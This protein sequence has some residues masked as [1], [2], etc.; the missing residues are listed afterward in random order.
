MKK[1]GYTIIAGCAVLGLISCFAFIGV[2]CSNDEYKEEQTKQEEQVPVP[3]YVSPI[4]P[5]QPEPE[6][7]PEPTP[8][9]E[10]RM[11]DIEMARALI[12]PSI[13]ET[14]GDLE[15]KILEQDGQLILM[16]HLPAEELAYV[17]EPVWN[18][19]ASNAIYAQTA[20]QDVFKSAGLNVN[21]SVCI[22]DMNRDRVYL[23]AN[24]GQIIYDVFNE[25]NDLQTN[26]F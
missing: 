24:N 13:K 9:V 26:S 18:D 22:G 23:A 4:E 1:Y 8:P 20:W 5:Q 19:L 11:S 15:Y 21:F 10:D 6:V 16:L 25:Q 3:E 14:I 7:E 2:S 17:T 12:E